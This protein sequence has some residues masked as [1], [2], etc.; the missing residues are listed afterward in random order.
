MSEMGID[1]SVVL[2]LS[3]WFWESLCV[4]LAVCTWQLIAPGKWSKWAR[5]VLCLSI[6]PSVLH[7]FGSVW[8]NALISYN[9]VNC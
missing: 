6:C 7:R 8:L 4:F 5:S 9:R 3:V 2:S 1:L